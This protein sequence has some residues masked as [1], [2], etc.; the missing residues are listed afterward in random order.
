M[1]ADGLF[2]QEKAVGVIGRVR[3]SIKRL[4]TPK[5]HI[6]FCPLFAGHRPPDQKPDEIAIR[7]TGSCAK[8]E[9]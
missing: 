8:C 9:Q 2:L 7:S 3:H 4:L 1:D 5:G 6:G